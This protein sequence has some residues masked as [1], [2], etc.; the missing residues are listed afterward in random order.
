MKCY[1]FHNN[2]GKKC[3]KESCRYWLELERHKNCTLLA[4]KEGPMTLQTIGDIFGITRMRV[5]QIEK[6]ILNKIKPSMNDIK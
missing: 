5:C 2:S 1:N 3:S 4:S 6:K